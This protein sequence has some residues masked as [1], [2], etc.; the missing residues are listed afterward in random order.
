MYV[1]DV[2]H[3]S[4]SFPSLSCW[5]CARLSPASIEVLLILRVCK[6]RYSMRE[7]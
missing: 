5:C 3:T 7:K 4:V 2:L 1:F 6:K